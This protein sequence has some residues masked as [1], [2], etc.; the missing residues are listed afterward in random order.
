M[1]NKNTSSAKSI[2]GTR[3]EQNIVNA[4]VSESGAY[5]RYMYYSQQA[6]KDKYFPIQKVFEETAQ[7]ELR[8]GKVFMKMLEGGVVPCNVDVDACKIKDTAFNLSIAIKEECQEGVEQYTA[9]AK[10]AK[11]EGFPEISSHFEAIAEIEKRHMDRF[12]R[13][14]D[15]V[16]SGTVWKRDHAI[17]W[18][19]LVCGY[20]SKGTEPPAECPAC[21]H[22]YQHYMGMDMD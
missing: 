15:Q 3:T 12:Q 20:E 6:E 9:A 7:N 21:D 5:T 10:V 22:P 18:K 14:L 1:A 17:T 19:C 16:K 2:K 4:Y 11:E 8:H 13:Y